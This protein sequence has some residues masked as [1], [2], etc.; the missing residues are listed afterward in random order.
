MGGA[1]R[2]PVATAGMMQ[3]ALTLVFVGHA[4]VVTYFGSRV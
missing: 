4:H 1:G 2:D 3:T